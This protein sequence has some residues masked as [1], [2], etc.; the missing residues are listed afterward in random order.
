MQA[1]KQAADGFRL[2][3]NSE[4]DVVPQLTMTAVLDRY[5]REFVTPCVQVA[6]GAVDD[7]KISSL[8]AKSYRSYIRGW[9]SPRWG[10]YFIADL[11]KP[12]LRSAIET[13]LA[14]LCAS[15]KLAPKT[16]RGIG[17]LMRL[18]FRR[19]IYAILHGREDLWPYFH[20]TLDFVKNNYFDQEDGGWF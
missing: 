9:I 20:E 5:E 18:I 6:L 19:A 17:S 12:Q 3:A 15:R 14:E 13:W 7:G 4:S 8:T 10:K 16:V 11:A 2:S 1:V